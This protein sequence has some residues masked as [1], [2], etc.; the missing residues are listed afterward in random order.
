[1]FHENESFYCYERHNESIVTFIESARTMALTYKHLSSS[2][3]LLFLGSVIALLPSC[4]DPEGAYEDFKDRYNTTN[5]KL[6]ASAPDGTS[7]DAAACV[8]PAQADVQGDY[9]FAL[10]ARLLP[11]KP[12]LG[13]G[14]I[15]I[16]QGASG[17]E[18][19]FSLQPLD[20]KDKKTPVGD[21]LVG[22]PFPIS[23]DG[24]FVAD[25]GNIQVTGAANPISGSDL[26]TTA[27]L[28]GAPGALCKPA[29]FFCGDVTGIVSKPL[30]NYDLAPGSHF[31]FQRITD[32]NAWPQ[33]AI[34]CQGT[35][36]P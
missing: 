7:D 8:V 31:T 11:T 18:L 4:A 27:T 30:A 24:S 10:S 32:P 28:T 9:L 12:I 14:T 16:T 15:T 34:D 1:M 25:L 35:K 29:D 6:D 36:A 3:K 22:G 26:V 17:P 23:A 13:I 5:G 19:S 33:A 20:A 2:A 21:P